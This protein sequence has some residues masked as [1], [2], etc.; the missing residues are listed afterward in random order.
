VT[1]PLRLGILGCGRAAE[2]LYLPAL[3]H[4]PEA[5]LA[6][7]FDPVQARRE[8]IASAVPGCRPCDS[9]EA[10]L[11]A[12]VDAVIV[13]TPPETHV[14]SAGP[15]LQAGLPVLVEKPLATTVGEGEE[16]AAQQAASG[17]PLAVGFNRRWWEPAVQLRRMLGEAPATNGTTVGMVITSDVRGWGALS[18][19]YDPL[20]DLGTHHLD[21]LRYLFGREIVAISARR[22]APMEI[23]MAVRLDGGVVAECL[24]A[25][26]ERSQERVAVARGGRRYLIRTGSERVRPERGPARR[27]LDVADSV[28]RRL[29]RGRSSMRRSFEQQLR[30]FVECVRGGSAPRAGVADGLAALRAVEAAR[31]SAAADGREV[32]LQ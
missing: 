31:A 16:L 18:G 17:V 24:A 29:T 11:R 14:A 20:D 9:A 21:L 12:G 25:Q 23:R 7:A 19:V 4:V 5:R 13:A 27:A 1:G 28:R 15:V 22:T 10:L 26:T 30:G 8:L 2:R 32:R 6:A 3:A